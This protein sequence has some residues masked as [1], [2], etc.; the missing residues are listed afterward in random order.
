MT[1]INF[2]ETLSNHGLILEREQTTTL[3]VNI[4]LMC[5]QEC[6]HCHLEAGPGRKEIMSWD[7]MEQIADFAATGQF[8]TI[9]ITGG[10]PELH[11]HLV[12][13]IENFA[14]I[15]TTIILRSN[16]SALY[17]K[18][19]PLMDH[20]KKHGV[21]ISASFPS[22]NEAQTESLRGRGFFQT[23]IETLKKL[24][25]LGYGL[26]DSNLELNLVVNPTG[27]FLPPSQESLEKQYKKTL[28][29]KWGVQFTRL[30]TFANVPLGRFRSWLVTSGNFDRY[31]NKLTSSFNPSAVQSLMCRNLLSVSWDGYLFDCD[32]NQAAGLFMKNRKTHISEIKRPPSMGEPVVVGDHCFTCTA[33]SGFT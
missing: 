4:G 25:E 6:V 11:P 18:G 17:T 9:D 5:N 22:L 30:F 2:S 24:N 31:M 32:F 27:A 16:L 15:K 3:Q 14:T 23:S 29:K 28:E 10:A 7:T 21:N 20:L 26:S 33:G 19:I 12:A 1:A 8:D 13:F